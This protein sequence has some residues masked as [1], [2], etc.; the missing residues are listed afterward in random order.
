M[1]LKKDK[2]WA[3]MDQNNFFQNICKVD[4][5]FFVSGNTVH[6]SAVTLPRNELL[7][8]LLGG[9]MGMGSSWFHIKWIFG[10]SVEKIKILGVVLELSGKQHWKFGPF[11]KQS[12]KMGWIG[13][14][15]SSKT[16]PRIL[17][18]FNCSGCQTFILY[19]IYCHLSPPKS[20]HNKSFLG[21]VLY[22]Y[23]TD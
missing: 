14:S 23:Y 7:C 8:Q 21:S 9:G 10:R 13:S 11:T 12:G 2:N 17:I 22:N 1:K 20:W 19:E 16:A 6:S 18:F 4:F 15:G 3:M 5:S